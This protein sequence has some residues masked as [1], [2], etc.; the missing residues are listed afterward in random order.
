MDCCI[1]NQSSI[2]F[3]RHNTTSGYIMKAEHIIVTHPYISEAIISCME[4][5]TIDTVLFQSHIVI[6]I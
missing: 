4:Q 1:V 2:H 3:Y 6:R 5:M